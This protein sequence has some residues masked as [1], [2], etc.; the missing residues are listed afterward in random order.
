MKLLGIAGFSGAGKTTLVTKL[1]PEL[2][3]RGVRVSTVKHAH[4]NFDV[5][6][7]G[8]DSYEHRHAGA[9]EVLVSS[10][11]RWALMHEHRGADEPSLD[12][13]VAKLTPVDL[14]LVE[15][16][17]FGDHKK[18]EVFRPSVAQPLLA[19]ED[20]NVVAI[21]TDA[22]TLDGVSVPLL[23]IDDIGAVADFVLSFI[24]W[25]G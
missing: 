18:L 24:G 2:T 1:I 9:M 10:P 14:V 5:D 12:E 7:P 4:H 25:E 21:A 11:Q 8:K 3:R 20:P 15:G 17:K 16:W 13:L 6:T 22:D 23:P 19:R